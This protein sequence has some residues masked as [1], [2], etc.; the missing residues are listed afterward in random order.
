M[1]RMNMGT[2]WEIDHFFPL[3]KAKMTE[4]RAGFLAAN[5]WRNLQPLTVE[6]NNAKGDAIYPEAQELFDQ[7][8]AEFSSYDEAHGEEVVPF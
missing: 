7:L 4:S 6:E 1:T 3:S 2:V 5:N 8:K